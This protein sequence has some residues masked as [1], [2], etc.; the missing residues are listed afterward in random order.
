MLLLGLQKY[1]EE[2]L[3][4]DEKLAWAKHHIEKGFA[5]NF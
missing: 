4:P 3:G 5:G 1:I 2:K